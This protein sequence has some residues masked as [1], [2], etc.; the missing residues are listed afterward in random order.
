MDEGR[1]RE[2]LHKGSQANSILQNPVFIEAFETLLTT[3]NNALLNTAP[4]Q[5]EERERCY[6]AISMLRQVRDEIENVMHTGRMAETELGD[7]RLH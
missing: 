3:Y 1:R 6:Y 7:P 4:D 5:V 2:E